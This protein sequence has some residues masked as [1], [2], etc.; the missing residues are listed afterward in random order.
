MVHQAAY[1]VVQQ[2]L[3]WGGVALHIVWKAVAAP[4]ATGQFPANLI[5]WGQFLWAP[6]ATGALVYAAFKFFFERWL[7]RWPPLSWLVRFPDL[8][9]SWLAVG[10]SATLETTWHA[11]VTLD[12]RFTVVH[13]H[14]WRMSSVQ[15]DLASS[16]ERERD[17]PTATTRLQIVYWN[18]RTTAPTK[19]TADHRGCLF[20][21]LLNEQQPRRLWRL[22]GD[23]WTDKVPPGQSAG[24][25]GTIELLFL[26]RRLVS[27][28]DPKVQEHIAAQPPQP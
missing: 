25:A 14:Q 23:Y 1:N 8:T 12:H 19:W 11:L 5:A 4:D 13:Y 15:H 28:D 22:H 21:T 24:T 18:K 10:Q 6:V 16:L 26:C 3:F 17:Q 2:A 20:V 7:W 27:Y 9:G